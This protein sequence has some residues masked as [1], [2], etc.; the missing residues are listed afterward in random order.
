MIRRSGTGELPAQATR[1]IGRKDE[2]RRVKR[3]LRV[4]RLVTVTGVAGIGKSRVAIRAASEVCQSFGDGVVFVE[5]AGVSDP[6][7]LEQAVAHALDLTDLSA[8]PGAEVL[9][10]HLRDR[11][12]LLV[13]DTCE[14]LVE[15]CAGLAQALLQSSPRLRILATSRQSLG[16]PGEHIVDLPPM[17]LPGPRAVASAATLS[18]C[19]AVTLFV[20]RAR[21][22]DP[23]YRLTDANAREVAEICAR[24]E[25]IPLAIELVAVRMGALPLDR[26]RALLDDRLWLL[27]GRTAGGRHPTV[28]ATVDWSHELCTPDERLLW[29]RLPVFVSSFEAAA[30]EEVC[31]DEALPAERVLPA[32]LGLV[33][34]SIVIPV[35]RGR[36]RSTGCWTSSGSTVRP[37]W[38]RAGT[39]GTGNGCAAAT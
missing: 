30:A 3:L 7:R 20:D 23:A 22:V 31:A 4:S 15:A 33:D 17:P 5:L 35:K 12:V 34:K 11:R 19:D 1:F 36:A 24:L 27:S 26:I 28:G 14:H 13:L 37:S 9:A 39:P 18:R 21:A 38:S 6:A 25:G 2:V 29:S 16:V 10:E 8:G 32:L